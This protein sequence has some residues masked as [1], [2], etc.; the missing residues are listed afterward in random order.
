MKHEHWMPFPE[1]HDFPAAT[2]YLSLIFSPKQAE[3]L[4]TALKSAEVETKK[5]KDLLRSSGLEA[6]PKDNVHVRK[7]LD[8][9]DKGELLSPVLL[10]R[11][12]APQ[13]VG[14][15]IAD[16]YHRICAS[17]LLDEDADIPC[18]IVDYYRLVG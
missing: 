17:Y 4:T 15:I 16:G 13:G 6:L 9:I 18:L 7:D 14:L 3:D 12:S 8:K 5:A 10:V 1:E 2:D 11:G